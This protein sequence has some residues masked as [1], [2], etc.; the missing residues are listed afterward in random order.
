MPKTFK[1][2]RKPRDHVSGNVNDLETQELTWIGL[3]T[4]SLVGK[5]KKKRSIMDKAVVTRRESKEK[6][7]NTK[8]WGP[9]DDV[10]L[11]DEMQKEK[12]KSKKHKGWE[13]TNKVRK[14][15]DVFEGVVKNVKKDFK[16][17]NVAYLNIFSCDKFGCI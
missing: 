12:R 5:P 9:I 14:I 17:S 2:A 15:K 10:N 11:A 4:I 13:P 3:N 8:V 6:G 1:V 16:N 7:V